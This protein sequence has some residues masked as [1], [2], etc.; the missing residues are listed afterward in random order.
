MFSQ[1]FM[2][3]LASAQRD[4]GASSPL[5]TV[6]QALQLE[7]QRIERSLIIKHHEITLKT[8]RASI[9]LKADGSVVIKGNDIR[10]ESGRVTVK[11]SNDLVLEG[12]RILEFEISGHKSGRAPR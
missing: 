9:V 12:A 1:E 11:A 6:L 2:H 4:A 7:V 10:L 3:T 8:G 5:A